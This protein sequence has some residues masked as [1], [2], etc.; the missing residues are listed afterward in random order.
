MIHNMITND[1]RTLQY[2][3]G[4]LRT[5]DTHLDGHTVLKPALAPA[6][7]KRY[8]EKAKKMPNRGLNRPG[9]LNSSAQV[10]YVT[11]RVMLI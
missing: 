11:L 3:P 4:H 5:L 9:R 8:L 2:L 7:T 6:A 1:I 10:K